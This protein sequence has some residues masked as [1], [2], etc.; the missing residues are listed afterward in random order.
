LAWVYEGSSTSTNRA[1]R[2][3]KVLFV[4]EIHGNR[5][6][7]LAI[8]RENSRKTSEVFCREN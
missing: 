1:G 7:I 3:G 5:Q 4:V 2:M 6:S 8:F